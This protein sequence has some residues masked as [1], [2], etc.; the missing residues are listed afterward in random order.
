MNDNLDMT[1]HIEKARTTEIQQ[2]WGSTYEVSYDE[3][4]YA[5]RAHRIDV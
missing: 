1:R 3:E 2:A 5:V 4:G